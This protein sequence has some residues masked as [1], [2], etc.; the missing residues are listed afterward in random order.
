MTRSYQPEDEL[1]FVP[2]KYVLA[3]LGSRGT[4]TAPI[5]AEIL[6]SQV[7]GEALPVAEHVRKALAPDR[8]LRRDLIRNPS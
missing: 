2:G 1:P 8:F 3:G 4:L 7:L 5:A 6:A